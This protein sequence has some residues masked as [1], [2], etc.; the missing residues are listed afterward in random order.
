ML[1][2]N[3][4]IS[5]TAEGSV[6]KKTVSSMLLVLAFFAIP[7]VYAEQSAESIVICA[8]SLYLVDSYT[9]SGAVNSDLCAE[10][11]TC[12]T[13]IPSLEDQGCKVINVVPKPLGGRNQVG[14]SGTVT[15]F[16]SCNRP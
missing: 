15:H 4:E 16:L 14:E 2:K 13:C 12:A 10:E 1:Y 3:D 8:R 6:M 9:L 5:I 7:G 11:H